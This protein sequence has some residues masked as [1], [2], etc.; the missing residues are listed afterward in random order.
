MRHV[1]PSSY[2]YLIIFPTGTEF[3][4]QLTNDGRTYTLRVD[5]TNYAGESVFAK[6][7]NFS[8]GPES[9]NYTLHVS[10]YDRS[11]TAG[12]THIFTYSVIMNWFVL[13]TKAQRYDVRIIDWFVGCWF[14]GR[15]DRYSHNS[16]ILYFLR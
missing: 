15:C 6:Y 8:V 4:H 12:E 7:G 10:E 9:D 11:S 3:I 16:F 1:Q 2:R 5:L 13:L 14:I